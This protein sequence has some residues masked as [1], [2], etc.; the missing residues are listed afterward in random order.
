MILQ[1]FISPYKN[2]LTARVEPRYQ[3]ERHTNTCFD[4]LNIWYLYPI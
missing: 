2:K 1:D 4:L 3:L